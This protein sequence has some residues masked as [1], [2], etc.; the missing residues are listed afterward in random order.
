MLAGEISEALGVKQNTLSANLA[1]LMNAGLLRNVREGR[2]IR[3]FA[4]LDGLRGLL[5]FLMQDC[6]GGAPELCQPILD[7]IT[8]A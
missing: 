4:D 6:C 8:C 1:I 5:R 2:T 3:Y 7:E